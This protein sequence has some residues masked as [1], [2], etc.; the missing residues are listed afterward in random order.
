MDRAGKDTQREGAGQLFRLRPTAFGV[1]TSASLFA[2]VEARGC[3]LQRLPNILIVE[4]RI[5][6]L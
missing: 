3:K 6:T 4:I 1:G 2:I 5:R